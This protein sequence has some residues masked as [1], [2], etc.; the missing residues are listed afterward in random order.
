VG[1]SKEG[2]QAE[3][4]VSF[5]ALAA[6]FVSRGLEF[7]AQEK[8]ARRCF[9]DKLRR[10]RGRLSEMQDIAGCRLIVKD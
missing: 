3:F 5:S 9:I 1:S 4:S 8:K 7:G 6:L 2:G 10:E